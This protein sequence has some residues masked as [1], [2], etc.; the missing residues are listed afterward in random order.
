MELIRNKLFQLQKE[1]TELLCQSIKFSIKLMNK[2]ILLIENSTQM[3]ENRTHFESDLLMKIKLFLKITRVVME[4]AKE[5]VKESEGLQNEFFQM[6]LAFNEKI[7]AKLYNISNIIIQTSILTKKD[8][9]MKQ[10]VVKNEIENKNPNS[11][12]MRC[13]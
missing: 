7:Q 1:K 11:V 5:Q 10:N 8:F 3:N 12:E 4:K 13:D 9:N 6:I 2:M